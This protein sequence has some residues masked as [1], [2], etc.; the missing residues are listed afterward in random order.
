MSHFF[1]HLHYYFG[2]VMVMAMLTMSS[3]H[4]QAQLQKI[5]VVGNLSGS[6]TATAADGSTRSLAAGSPVYLNDLIDSKASSKAQ[7]MFLDKSA[8]MVNPNTQVTV[9]QFVYNPATAD[10]DLSMKSVKGALRFIGGALSKEKPVT[11]KTPVA[12]IGIRGGI[13]D[14]H[15]GAG[16]ATDA[17]FVYGEEMTMANS[18]GQM[19]SI[20]T[21]GQGLSVLDAS[22]LPQPLPPERIMQHMASFSS[23]GTSSE[24]SA[25]ENS[26]GSDNAAGD[27][28]TTD[29]G[30]EGQKEGGAK[31]D[32]D[33]PSGG[34]KS[35][36]K[37]QA[38][39][40]ATRGD[41][42]KGSASTNIANANGGPNGSKPAP[43]SNMRVNHLTGD[44]RQ[45][46]QRGDNVTTLTTRNIEVTDEGMYVLSRPNGTPISAGR[47]EFEN[48]GER[49]A[50]RLVQGYPNPTPGPRFVANLPWLEKDGYQQVRGAN[51]EGKIVGGVGY[52]TLDGGMT[53]YDIQTGNGNLRTI[54]GDPLSQKEMLASVSASRAGSN[55]N[56]DEGIAF[57]DFLPEMAR[58]ADLK[59][60]FFDYNIV[61][62]R[63]GG[64]SDAN[65]N[66]PGLM[67]DWGNKRF[68]TGR[69]NW[70]TNND[71]IQDSMVLAFGKAV[72]G[73]KLLDGTMMEYVTT[74]HN[75]PESGFY[76]TGFIRATDAYSGGY[77]EAFSGMLLEGIIPDDGTV[78]KETAYLLDTQGPRVFQGAVQGAV[79]ERIVH[80]GETMSTNNQYG[81]AAGFKESTQ[82]GN[83]TVT[84]YGNDYIEDVK[85]VS[86][87]SGSAYGKI[88]VDNLTHHNNKY[89]KAE[90]GNVSGTTDDQQSAY[91]TDEVYAAQLARYYVGDYSGHETYTGSGVNN[92]AM[93]SAQHISNLSNSCHSCE[94]VHWG[95][96]AGEINR[97]D[98]SSGVKIDERIAM[99]PYV[100]GHVTQN[101][102]NTVTPQNLGNVNYTGPIIGAVHHTSGGITRHEGSFVAG[103]DLNNRQLTDFNG[104]L[105][106]MNFG[107][108][109]ANHDIAQSGFATF[110]DVSVHNLGTSTSASDITG[111]INGALFGANAEDI[112][113]NFDIQ[114][115][116]TGN[117]AAGVYLGTRQ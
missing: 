54:I 62:Q 65:A 83:V 113:G 13:A 40:A 82:G 8:L 33:T 42:P 59:R 70:A 63:L 5:G 1:K 80:S 18:Q 38:G 84:R 78:N 87:G 106:G 98:P 85:V 32:G 17:I 90:F 53:Y 20:T 35:D 103:I 4:A 23:D 101:L 76:K 52:R 92:S 49:Y 10:G 67:I 7:I 55:A 60:T 12:T 45:E 77:G 95:V 112:G 102:K 47:A 2:L 107:F 116:V 88:K 9:D 44:A 39:P 6:V 22:S 56:V 64:I 48:R 73:N 111:T 110:R 104:Q 89:I 28:P 79:N 94:F 36:G 69:V 21:P 19:Q 27:S 66:R 117:Q 99:M 108:T 91:L 72:Q 81:F 16:G 37:G 58:Y 46:T 29:G 93:T 100:A 11:I 14:T 109:D 71:T 97:S 68:F 86:S 41:K 34:E 25:D 51:I 96:W 26:A 3:G 30:S 50:G 31:G 61:D 75:G 74:K 43:L 15:I 115:T 114:H 105:A 57:Y 24:G